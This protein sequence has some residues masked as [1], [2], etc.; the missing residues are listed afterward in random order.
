MATDLRPSPAGLR[1]A[2][3]LLLQMGKEGSAK[4]MARLREA[5]VEALSAEIVRLG[6]VDRAV[7]S[8]VLEEFHAMAR[9]RKHI[10]H[11][12]MDYARDLLVQTLGADRAEEI[13]GRLSA[14]MLEAPFRSLQ[15]A[16]P[17]QVL[18]FLAEEH[19]QTIALVVAH[20][21]AQLA[22]MVLSGLSAERQSDVALRVATMSRT[23]PEVV[24]KVEAIIERKVSSLLQPS[25]LSTIGGVKPLVDIINRSD[26][27]TERSILEGLAE[28]APDLA[29]EVRSQMFM[30]DDLVHIDDRSIQLLLRQVEPVDL[31]TALKGVRDD[32]RDKVTHNLSERA[33]ENLLEEIQLLGAIRLRTVE[34]AQAKIISV[35]RSLEDSGQ[36]VLRRGDDDEFVD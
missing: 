8:A 1:K 12:G 7:T 6:T 11:G 22:S 5:E 20:M 3:V 15:R 13:V 21:P 27:V 18:S 23:S 9:A 31:A 29:D 28:R 25:D 30:F 10:A 2:A 32:V 24:R 16:D 35:I 26:R 36:L 4:L 14:S 19:P 33:A 17:R 34:E